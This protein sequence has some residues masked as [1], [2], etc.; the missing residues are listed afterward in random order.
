MKTE[1][2]TNPLSEQCID[3]LKANDRK[4]HTVPSS[5][6]YPHQWLW[7]SCF[8]AIGWAQID[9]K[10]AEQE[11]FSLFKGQWHNGMIPHMIFDMSSQYANDRNCGAAGYLV[12][13][14]I[15]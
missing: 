14:Q 11:I 15:T 8:S 4:T 13:R 7:D 6:L 10:R 5:G 1:A 3:V 12:T 9:V 2:L